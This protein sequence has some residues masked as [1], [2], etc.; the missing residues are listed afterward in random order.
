MSCP[1]AGRGWWWSMTLRWRA[2]RCSRPRR[3]RRG[4]HGALVSYLSWA[5]DTY[6]VRPG[7]PWHG[8]LAFDLAITSVFL[9]LIAGAA[10]VASAEGEADGLAALLSQGRGF[11]VVRVVPAPLPVLAELSPQGL[12]GTGH[13]VIGGEALAAADVVPW[14]DRSPGL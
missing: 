5:K 9:P 7:V 6:R 13:L 10:V 14:L 2:L 8:S 3:G 4:S 12:A 1:R 11:G